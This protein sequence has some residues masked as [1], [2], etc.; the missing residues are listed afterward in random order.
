M[1]AR[2]GPVIPLSVSPLA[3]PPTVSLAIFAGN[4]TVF[5]QSPSILLPFLHRFGEMYRC[6]ELISPKLVSLSFMRSTESI[7][8]IY[9]QSDVTFTIFLSLHAETE[10]SG[11]R[12]ADLHNIFDLPL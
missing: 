11:N 8:F 9:C 12:T 6:V 4:A 10:I 1:V 7:H 5:V 3:L 2:I